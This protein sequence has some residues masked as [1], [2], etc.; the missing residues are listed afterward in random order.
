MAGFI[1][2]L[3]SELAKLPDSTREQLTGEDGAVRLIAP[4]MLTDAELAACRTAFAQVLGHEL[5]IQVTVDPGDDRRA[6]TG[7]AACARAQQFSCAIWPT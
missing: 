6:R 4:R 3:C 2:G 5:K 7:S 1:D